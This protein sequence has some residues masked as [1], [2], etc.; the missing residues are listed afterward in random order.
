MAKNSCFSGIKYSKCFPTRF[1]QHLATPRRQSI[2]PIIPHCPKRIT[3]SK[4]LGRLISAAFP[5][6]K[7]TPKDYKEI[8]KK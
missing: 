6:N 4:P 7:G 8:T 2:S 1:L 5:L 3:T